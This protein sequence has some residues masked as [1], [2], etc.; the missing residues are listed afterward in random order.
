MH[1]VAEYPANLIIMAVKPHPVGDR[2]HCSN[3]SVG[4]SF[5]FLLAGSFLYFMKSTVEI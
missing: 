4:S 3:I 5:V 2:W 1:E